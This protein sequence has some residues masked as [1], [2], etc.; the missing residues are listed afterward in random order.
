MQLGVQYRLHNFLSGLNKSIP[1][2]R[3]VRDAHPMVSI[4]LSNSLLS[5]YYMLTTVL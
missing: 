1:V 4:S 5:T 2:P 3:K